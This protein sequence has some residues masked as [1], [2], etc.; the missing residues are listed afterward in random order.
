MEKRHPLTAFH[1]G[2]FTTPLTVL[3]PAPRLG[4]HALEGQKDGI[5][6][7][8]PDDHAAINGNGWQ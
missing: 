2:S 4:W 1:R 8:E 7:N 3:S 6:C 5:D